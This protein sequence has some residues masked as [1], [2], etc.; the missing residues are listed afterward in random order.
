MSCAS[1]THCFPSNLP[2]CLRLSMRSNSS[3]R[4]R[5]TSERATGAARRRFAAPIELL[6]E[7]ICSAYEYGRWTAE[8]TGS[9]EASRQWQAT[10]IKLKR[11][12]TTYHA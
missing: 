9:D 11:A 10:A 3:P 4:N 6:E 1:P 5:S 7:S 2:G 8:W 12:N